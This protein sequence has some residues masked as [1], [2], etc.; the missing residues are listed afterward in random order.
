M[1]LCPHRQRLVIDLPSAE[2]PLRAASNQTSSADTSVRGIASTSQSASRVVHISPYD[3]TQSEGDDVLITDLCA[4]LTNSDSF[5]PQS[6]RRRLG[7]ISDSNGHKFDLST[8]FDKS[9]FTFARQSI[10]LADAFGK[11]ISALG[12]TVARKSVRFHM[13]NR[14]RVQLGLLLAWGVLQISSTSWLEGHWTKDN[15]LLV[16]DPPNKPHPYVSHC[17]Q[18]K[19][20]ISNGSSLIPSASNEIMDWTPNVPLFALARFLLELCYESSIEDLAQ[21]NEL[22]SGRPHEGTPLLTVM[23]LARQVDGELGPKYARVVKACLNPPFEMD[24]AGRAKDTSEFAQSMMR[25]VIEPLE[26]IVNSFSE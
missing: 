6:P 5:D 11:P 19:R 9:T 26:A 8:R 17:F 13:S 24:G 25:N 20:R 16:I 4:T 2:V 15:I 18:S 3:Q 21:A 22:N 1:V 10:K 12:P 14:D 7:S 23:R